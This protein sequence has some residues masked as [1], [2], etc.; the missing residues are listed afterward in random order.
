MNQFLFSR[1]VTLPGF[2]TA[3]MVGIII[4]NSSAGFKI[5]LDPV[6]RERASEISL[7]LFPAMSATE[8]DAL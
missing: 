2:L 1:G 8:R 7:Q 5:E 4:I 3:M 6:A